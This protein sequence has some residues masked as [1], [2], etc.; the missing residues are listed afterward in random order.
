VIVGVS[1]K[2]RG[3]ENV[4]KNQVLNNIIC[5]MIDPRNFNSL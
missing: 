3:D 1:E 2:Q 5:E 4:F